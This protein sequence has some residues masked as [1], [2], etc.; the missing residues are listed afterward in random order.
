[1]TVTLGGGITVV[2]TPTIEWL[3]LRPRGATWAAT[4]GSMPTA[5]VVVEGW[6][7]HDEDMPDELSPAAA[8]G[9]A[10]RGGS[11]GGV[12]WSA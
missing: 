4:V 6:A 7:C 8:A 5:E 10:A 1:M 3:W 11:S 9:L 2:D 12:S